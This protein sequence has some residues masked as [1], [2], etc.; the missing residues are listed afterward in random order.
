MTPT[1]E[2]ARLLLTPIRLADAEQAQRIF[3]QWEVVKYL[4]H[5]MIL[6]PMLYLVIP[7]SNA[8]NAGNVKVCFCIYH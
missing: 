3:P 2:P 7:L 8:W 1:L 5:F 6:T 4:F